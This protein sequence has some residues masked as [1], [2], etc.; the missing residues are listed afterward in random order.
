MAETLAATIAATM[1]H[2]A[3]LR[4]GSAAPSLSDGCSPKGRLAFSSDAGPEAVMLM[5]APLLRARGAAD[6]FPT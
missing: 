3:C 5:S 4:K 1:G 2:F 6:L